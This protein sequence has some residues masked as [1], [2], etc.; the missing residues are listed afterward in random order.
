MIA[1]ERTR[2]TPECAELGAL[3]EMTGPL[4]RALL[5]QAENP[6]TATDADQHAALAMRAARLALV[7]A[8]AWTHGQCRA[9]RADAGR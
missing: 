3:V 5:A 1:T 6:L 4:L 9:R 2:C 8:E 7:D